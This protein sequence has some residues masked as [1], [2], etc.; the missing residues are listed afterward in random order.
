[1]KAIPAAVA[2]RHPKRYRL[3]AYRV[4]PV[5]RRTDRLERGCE[6]VPVRELSSR[7]VRQSYPP[8]CHGLGGPL[9]L[10]AGGR[11]RDGAS[12]LLAM[13]SDPELYQPLRYERRSRTVL[14]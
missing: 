3:A 9:D 8:R 11:N 14:F 12:P 13:K 1:M 4:T 7:R 2:Q 6:P 10:E 5:G